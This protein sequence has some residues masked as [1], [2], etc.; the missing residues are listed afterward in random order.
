VL[1]EHSVNR[2]SYDVNSMREVG[3]LWGG[4]E[5]Y[6]EWFTDNVVS[7]DLH[8]SRQ[9][10]S[11][12]RH[13]NTNFYVPQN[14][15]SSLNRPAGVKLFEHDFLEMYP[16]QN[17]LCCMMLVSGFHDIVLLH[18]FKVTQELTGDKMH[19]RNEKG[20]IR[21]LKNCVISFPDTQY[22]AIDTT[23][24]IDESLE[25]L[26]NFTCDTYENVLSLLLDVN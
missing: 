6:R 25:E 16:R 10:I 12:S 1:D 3:P 19:D 4:I 26:E 23:S 20:Y 2:N 15:F 21:E 14:Q 9:F 13:L 24:N 11:S 7:L 5:T 8:Q 18:Q 22:V 17:Q